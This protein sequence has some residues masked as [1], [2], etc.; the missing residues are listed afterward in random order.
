MKLIFTSVFIFEGM[1]GGNSSRSTRSNM[2]TQ[3]RTKG[4]TQHD[5]FDLSNVDHVPSSAEFLVPTRCRSPL[6]RTKQWLKMIFKGGSPTPTELLLI[7][8]LTELVLTPRFKS[9]VSTQ[10]HQLAD[11]LTKDHSTRDQWNNLLRLLIINHFRLLCCSQH[12]SMVSCT[13]M[14]AKRMQEQQGDKI[15]A[16][17]KPTMNLAFTVSTKIST[18]ESDWV[19]SP[20]DIQSTLYP[21][22][23]GYRE[24]CWRYR[25]QSKRSVE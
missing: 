7:G 6:R 20:G 24:T 19:E 23:V 21:R 11:M 18:A 1:V 9:S 16:E 2:H 12:F 14:M 15:V 25:I 13:E 5:H 10:N 17:S 8:C 3:N 22:L 4:P